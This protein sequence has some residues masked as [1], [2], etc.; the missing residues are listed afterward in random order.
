[1]RV[2]EVPGV[3]MELCGGTHVSNTSE[4]RAFKIISEQG[5]ASG[6][7]RIEAVAGEAFIEY[8]NARDS[9]MKLLC[10]TLKVCFCFSPLIG[11]VYFFHLIYIIPDLC[12]PVCVLSKENHSAFGLFVYVNLQVNKWIYWGWIGLLNMWF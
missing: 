12:L 3:S 10:S 11:C 9:Q 4:I 7:R 6:I 8:I 2:V 5:I 1:M